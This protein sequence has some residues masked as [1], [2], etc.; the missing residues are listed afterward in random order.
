MTKSGSAWSGYQ[1]GIKQ[2]EGAILD[3]RSFS[4]APRQAVER[5]VTAH[6]DSG[7]PERAE[8]VIRAAVVL[9]P[10]TPMWNEMLGDFMYREG[11]VYQATAAYIDAFNKSASIR[12]LARL[13]D[14]TRSTERWDHDAALKMVQTNQ[15]ILRDSPFLQSIQAKALARVRANAGKGE[16]KLARDSYLKAFQAGNLSEC[17]CPAGTDVQVVFSNEDPNVGEYSP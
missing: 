3:L 7:N 13:N 11:D 14:V 10:N 17:G 5:L 1:S 4:D 8:D 6:M 15:R 16:I 12:L 9:E 2:H